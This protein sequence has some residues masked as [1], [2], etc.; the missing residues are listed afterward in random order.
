MHEKIQ[1]LENQ[2]KNLDTL[3]YEDTY[4]SPT[5]SAEKP[6]SLDDSVKKQVL[7]HMKVYSDAEKEIELDDNLNRIYEHDVKELKKRTVDYLKKVGLIEQESDIERLVVANRSQSHSGDINA[8]L[9]KIEECKESLEHVQSKM[10]GY[11]RNLQDILD[12]MSDA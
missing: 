3:E 8:E 6:W 7:N 10:I 9:K 2:M 1:E 4:G 5:N 12:K 11:R